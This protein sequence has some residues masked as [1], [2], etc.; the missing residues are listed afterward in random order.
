MNKIIKIQINIENEFGTGFRGEMDINDM[1]F[2]EYTSLLSY[3]HLAECYKKAVKKLEGFSMLTIT[4]LSYE[5][6]MYRLSDINTIKSIRYTNKYGEVKRSDFNEYSY[7]NFVDDS[8][9]TI[10][11]SIKEMV[12]RGNKEFIE[13]LKSNK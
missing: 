6:G 11:P 9:K 13:L 3:D 10:L 4:L 2:T 1:I 12:E 8:I 5:Q 7:N